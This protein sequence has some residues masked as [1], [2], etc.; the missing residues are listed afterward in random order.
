MSGEEE[1]GRGAG[2]R[3]GQ[4]ERGRGAGRGA[5]KMS[6]EEERGRGAGKSGGRGAG[7]RSGEEER[8]RGERT[9]P[10][11]V[12]ESA[13]RPQVLLEPVAGPF[14]SERQQGVHRERPRLRQRATQRL[15]RNPHRDS[16]ARR[17]TADGATDVIFKCSSQCNEISIMR[18][19]RF[20]GA[21]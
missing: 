4:G 13:E 12:V 2:K 17:A 15:P 5:G 20:I 10:D 8:G 14:G 18:P 7:K 19:L 21:A 6:G 9:C 3:S 16:A 11:D 1:R